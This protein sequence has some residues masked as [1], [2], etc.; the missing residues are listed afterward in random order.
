MLFMVVEYC[1]L[2]MGAMLNIENIRDRL[3]CPIPAQMDET[4]KRTFKMPAFVE[5]PCVGV[6]VKQTSF[7]HPEQVFL[8]VRCSPFFCVRVGESVATVVSPH[9]VQSGNA[10]S[11]TSTGTMQQTPEL[12]D[13]VERFKTGGF[14][15]FPVS[16]VRAESCGVNGE[17]QSP[18]WDGEGKRA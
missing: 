16:A 15:F 7:S 18:S 10:I 17:E 13:V 2:E 1:L 14:S 5:L 9:P 6:G 4:A 8:N 11:K 12:V 3:A